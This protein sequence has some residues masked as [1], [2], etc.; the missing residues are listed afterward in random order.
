MRMPGSSGSS[1]GSQGPGFSWPNII[2]TE[3]IVGGGW[4]KVSAVR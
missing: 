3:V 1:I 2:Q 4:M